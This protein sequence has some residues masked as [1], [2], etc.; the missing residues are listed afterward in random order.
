MY[1]LHCYSPIPADTH[2][3]PIPY[4]ASSTPKRYLPSTYPPSLLLREERV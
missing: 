3:P 2:V 1:E 4:K